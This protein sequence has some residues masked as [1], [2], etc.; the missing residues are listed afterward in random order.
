MAGPVLSAAGELVMGDLVDAL[1]QE[2]LFGFGD[3]TPADAGGGWHRVRTS[4]GDGDGE[5][6]LRLR[7]CVALQRHRFAR[8]PV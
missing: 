7:E 5:V 8:G 6:R 2:G 3:A 1:I 4:D